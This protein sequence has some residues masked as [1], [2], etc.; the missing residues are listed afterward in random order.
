RAMPSCAS[1]S[2]PATV[3]VNPSPLRPRDKRFSRLWPAAVATLLLVAAGAWYWF[4]EI[5]LIF[6]RPSSLVREID[7][8]FRR[9]AILGRRAYPL[10]DKPS[11]AILPFENLSDDP[12]QEIFVDAVTEDI[13]VVLASISDLFV[14]DR[15]TALSFKGRSVRVQQVA[16]ELGVQYVLEGSVRR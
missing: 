5:D 1:V 9:R 12:A 2:A 7:S 6:F 11:I 8:V 16:E 3:S 14:I 4:D 10:P 13:T 15:G